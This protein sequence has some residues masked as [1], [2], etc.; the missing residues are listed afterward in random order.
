VVSFTPPAALLS[1]EIA[2]GT[3]SRGGWVGP[4][5]R[6]GRCGEEKK[7]VHCRESNPGRPARCYTDRAIPA[8][9]LHPYQFICYYIFI[10]FTLLFIPF[11]FIPPLTPALLKS[12][13]FL[14]HLLLMAN[15]P[16]LYQNHFPLPSGSVLEIETKYT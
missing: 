4:Q 16:D 8:P 7:I 6:S 3:H 12:Y 10:C 2:S 1:G 11:S 9:F 15:L 13:S 5:S 14:C